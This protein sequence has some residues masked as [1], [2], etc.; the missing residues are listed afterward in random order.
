M[1]LKS[2]IRPNRRKILISLLL[3]GITT[4]TY[5]APSL[6]VN[7]FPISVIFLFASFPFFFGSQLFDSAPV[8]FS[9]A[10]YLLLAYPF[11][12]YINQERPWIG[13]WFDKVVLYL[14]LYVILSFL[15]YTGVGF[16]NDTIGRSCVTDTDCKFVCGAGYVNNQH[17]T[18]G[19]GIW[20]HGDCVGPFFP[21]CENKKCEGFPSGAVISLEDCEKIPQRY[22]E[23]KD[24]C[25]LHLAGN[26]DDAS[27]CTKITGETIKERCINLVRR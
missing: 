11:A 2:F 16:Y 20:G 13:G 4:F 15:I 22:L 18:L 23:A 10:I 9:I 26:L 6:T 8:Y 19:G 12:C 25:Y 7:I 27:A 24:N 3:I 1:D 5:I 14:F 21:H 17:I